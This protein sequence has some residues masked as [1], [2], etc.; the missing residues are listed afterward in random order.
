MRNAQEMAEVITLLA[1][2]KGVSVN[3]M[4]LEC[5][6]GKSLID[7]MKRGRDPSAS[8]LKLVAD[9]LGVT[10][11]YLLTKDENEFR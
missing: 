9:Y 7:N 6:A 4:V 1:R 2:K 8:K 10:V 5:G 3:K 11:D